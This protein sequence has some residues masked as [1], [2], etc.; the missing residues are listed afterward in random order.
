MDP[1]TG[2][3]AWELALRSGNLEDGSFW[4]RNSGIRLGVCQCIRVPKMLGSMMF[5]D[6]RGDFA[7]KFLPDVAFDHF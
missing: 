4:T 7:G 6:F 3:R 1:P 5:H 2:P